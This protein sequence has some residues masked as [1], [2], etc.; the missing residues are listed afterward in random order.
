MATQEIADTGPGA[1]IAGDDPS[2]SNTIEES[3]IE[4]HGSPDSS[5]SLS[6]STSSVSIRSV[7]TGSIRASTP[8]G[9][10]ECEV[11]VLYEGPP[12]CPCCKNWVEEYPDDLRIALEEQPDV[13][14]KA[15]VVRMRKNHGDGKPLVL[16]SVVIQSP[17]LKETLGE[18][19]QGYSG[20]TASLKKVVFKS[21]FRPFYSRWQRFGQ[22]LE[23]QKKE[24]PASAAVSQLLYDVLYAELHDTMTE[25]RDLIEH[26]VIT[27]PLL[28]ALFEP[29]KLVVQ[30]CQGEK[31]FYIFE[32]CSYKEEG[33]MIL[34]AKFVDWDSHHFGYA[35]Q[36]LEIRGF[37]GTRNITEL[38]LFPAQFLLS[39]EEIEAVA[40]RRG[41]KFQALREFHYMA[42]SGY[43]E[44]KLGKRKV[45]GRIIIDAVSF[46]HANPSKRLVLAPLNNDPVMPKIQVAD[47]T[48]LQSN[49]PG[50]PIPYPGGSRPSG[51]ND[52]HILREVRKRKLQTGELPLPTT[53]KRETVA[54]LTQEQLLLCNPYVR[55]YS[56]K[57]KN[58]FEFRVEDVYDITWNDA[59]FPS[60]ILPKGLKD[61]ILT[62]VEG[63]SLNKVSFDDVIEGKGQGIIMMLVGNPGTGKTLTAEAIADKVRKPLYIL[64]AGELGQDAEDVE[65]R[66]RS[67]LTLTEKWNAILLFDE[68]D[69]F[70]QER[71]TRDLAHNE[72]VAVF[73]R[74]LE[75]YRGILFMTSN[76]AETIDRAFHSRIHLTL[77]YPDLEPTAR[78]H[79]WRQFTR[80]SQFENKLSDD[81]LKHLAKLPLNGRQIKNVVKIATLLAAQQ[82]VA[83]GI[84]QVQTVLEATKQVSA[85]YEV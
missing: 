16:D 82:N 30:D 68:C 5:E 3:P 52:Q 63:Q 56:L 39:R 33:C 84:D 60:L 41:A 81:Y 14:L 75:Y 59:A 35:T 25:I 11:K 57:L 72:I 29:G 47:E 58:W 74:L 66:L 13:K 80:Q 69:V 85:G 17:S 1:L 28:W 23:R 10:H 37:N 27:Y 12:K 26:R 36:F 48:H 32:S 64:S 22:V 40:I 70:I 18:V 45:D 9:D 15:L 83:L 6:A 77:H 55:G 76:R 79:I 8:F 19:F 78:E 62:F 42:H 2:L 43:V 61:L 51:M 21:P 44:H 7:S 71:T 24:D 53:Q 54:D 50:A 65:D 67:V 34:A 73:L 49:L 4:R 20:I 31:R 38:E 46:F